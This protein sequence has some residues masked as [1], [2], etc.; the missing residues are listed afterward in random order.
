LPATSVSR[1]TGFHQLHGQKTIGGYITDHYL[2]YYQ[3]SRNAA[4]LAG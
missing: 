3:V 4:V 2:A 1:L